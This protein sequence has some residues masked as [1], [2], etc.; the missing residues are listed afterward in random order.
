MTPISILGVG[1]LE[2]LKQY[3][4]PMHFRKALIV[5]DKVLVE[6]G[7]IEQL[8]AILEAEGIFYVIHKDVSPNPTVQQVDFGLKLL[9]DNGCDFLISFGGGS[10]HD[11]A[12]AIG[13]LATNGGDIRNYEGTNKA[14][15]PSVPLIAINTT[16]G[17]GSEVTRYCVITDEAR[18]VKMTI[19]DW[20]TTPVIAVCDAALMTGMPP[21]LTAATGMDALTHAIE[22]FTSSNATP[23]SDC[24]AIKAVELTF[25]HLCAA[26]TDGKNLKAR[27]GMA[28]AEFL[29]G[30]AFNNAGLGYVHALAH[31]LGGLYNLPHGLCN[32]ILLPAVMEFN[33]PVV[34]DKYAVIAHAVGIDT[35]GL[36][37]ERSGQLAIERIRELNRDLALPLKLRELR[38][39]KVEDIPK[40]AELALNDEIG[41]TN[42]RQG[43]QKEIEEIYRSIL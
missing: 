18:H 33:L 31:Q 4:R 26:F 6:S 36:A 42:P 1:C 30:M 7:L 19:N 8:L 21:G 20:H 37:A 34:A 40:L 3:M 14:A 38:G 23:V 24:K 15:K 17:T 22:A 9:Q 43:S 27:E 35:K 28:Y 12:K 10:P 16:A 39:F 13:L 2:Q 5:S 25:E 32:A 11:C 29:A 41:L